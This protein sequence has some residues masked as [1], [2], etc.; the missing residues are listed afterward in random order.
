[1]LKNKIEDDNKGFLLPRNSRRNSNNKFLVWQLYSKLNIQEKNE[2]CLK[3]LQDNL[4]DQRFLLY[5]WP[6]Q[7]L[8]SKYADKYLPKKSNLRILELGPGDNLMTSALW[9]LEKRVSKI[10]LLDKYQGR[11]IHSADYHKNLIDLIKTIKFLPRDNFN[12][13]YPFDETDINRLEATIRINRKNKIELDTNRIIYQTIDDFSQIPFDNNSFDY[14]YSHA[15]LEHHENPDLSIKEMFRVLNPGGLMVHQIDMR[16]HRY[17]E[18]DPYRFLEI[19]TEEWK[20][21]NGKYIYPL[22]QWRY[23]H[24]KNSFKSNGFLIIEEC[25]SRREEE[26]TKG[27]KFASEFALLPRDEL[28]ITGITFILRKP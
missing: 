27:I 6:V 17:F 23:P 22:N 5:G 26:K 12:N 9:M 21:E 2:L 13:Y 8:Y 20:L 7:Q 1:M 4:S 19:S 24:Y 14:I 15:T 10:T 11:Y 16:D 28:L 25:K 18:K 3:V